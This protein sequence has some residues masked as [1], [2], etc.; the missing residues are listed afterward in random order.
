MNK[1]QDLLTQ[2][3]EIKTFDPKILIKNNIICLKPFYL[4]YSFVMNFV[5]IAILGYV[6]TRQNDSLLNLAC[7]ILFGL[8]IVLIITELRYYNTIYIN[9]EKKIII[10]EPN[11]I[12]SFLKKKKI[13]KFEDIRTTTVLSNVSSTGFLLV[14]RRYYITLILNDTE[15]IKLIQSTKH[16]TA[17]KI[18]EKIFFIL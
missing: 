7:L 17:L 6:F 18:S 13:I 5:C 8:F 16:D 14:N 3:Q 2:F 15:K 4:N 11:I 1:S 9:I 12:L 10:I